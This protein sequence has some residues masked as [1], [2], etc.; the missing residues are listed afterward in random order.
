MKIRWG[1][2]ITVLL[3]AMLVLTLA[4]ACGSKTAEQPN[5][6]AKTEAGSDSGT[7][8]NTNTNNNT[9]SGTTEGGGEP[10]AKEISGDFEIQ[11]FVGGYGDQGWKKILAAFKEKYPNVNIKESAGPKINEQ[12]KPRWISGDTPDFVYIDGAGSNAT[13]MVLDG[14]LMDLTD[15]IKE[16]KNADGDKIMDQLLLQPIQYEGDKYY[17]IPFVFGSWGIFY[18]KAEFTKNNWSEPTDFE[19]F[20]SISKQIQDSGKMYPLIFTGKY[21]YY[22]HGGILD[23]AFVVNNDNDTSILQRMAA[24]EE[25]IFKSEPVKKALEQMVKIRDAKIIDPASA[26]I[27]HTDSQ[28]MFLQHKD[29]FI[30]N[31]LWLENEM[32]KDVPEGFDF[33]FMPSITQA[34][35]GKYIAIPFTATVAISKNAK[36]PDAAK[37]FLEFLFTKQSATTWAVET[38]ALGNIKVD[39][40]NSDASALSKRAMKFY[41]SDNTIVAPYVQLNADVDTEK[42][43]AT[44][45]L[46]TGKIQPEEWMD[47]LEKAAAKARK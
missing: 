43:N 9:D 21:P 28:A 47:R 15:Y 25:G 45:A 3:I 14:Q 22:F 34:P 17:D 38:G 36:N 7:D 42:Q 20:M 18:D 33:G 2:S 40:E 29:A 35:G 6:G 41:G 23:S 8:T 32:K 10:A 4:A 16:A 46:M 11:Y 37:A 39:L 31:G 19:S 44:L 24:L 30:P 26:Q 13:Q 27:N 12:M 1:K 5:E